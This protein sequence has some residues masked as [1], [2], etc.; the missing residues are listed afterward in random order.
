MFLGGTLSPSGLQWINYGFIGGYYAGLENIEITRYCGALKYYSQADNS[1][2]TCHSSCLTCIS[3]PTF[4]SSCSDGLYLSPDNTCN[5]CSQGCEFC[6]DGDLCSCK[7][8]YYQ[9]PDSCLLCSDAMPGCYTCDLQNQCKVCY[10]SQHW[11]PADGQCRCME[12]YFQDNNQCLNC[13]NFCLNCQSADLCV[14]CDPE[15]HTI[16]D[17]KGVCQCQ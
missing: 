4:C 5:P 9:S 13:P 15:S 7:D 16:V 6:R 12:R 2:Q 8:S 17:E 3:S 10:I 11:E 14:K 1:C